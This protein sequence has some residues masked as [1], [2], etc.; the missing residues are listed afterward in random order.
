[1]QIPLDTEALER[2]GEARRGL[3][4]YLEMAAK[5]LELLESVLAV[6]SKCAL[7]TLDNQADF[8]S[9]IRRFDPSRPSQLIL[10]I[11]IAFSIASFGKAHSAPVEERCRYFGRHL[12]VAG[13]SDAVIGASMGEAGLQSQAL[14]NYLMPKTGCYI[15]R[16]VGTGGPGHPRVTVT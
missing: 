13:A 15:V 6:F 8:D 12:L 7:K 2:A 4:P 14:I 5:L 10:L 11:K 16:S 1:M 3:L 9:A